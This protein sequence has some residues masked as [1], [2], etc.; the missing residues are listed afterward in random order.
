L[1]ESVIF[2]SKVKISGKLTLKA[3]RLVA[4]STERWQNCL[5]RELVFWSDWMLLRWEFC[6]CSLGQLP[7]KAIKFYFSEKGW[8]CFWELFSSDR[9]DRNALEGVLAPEIWF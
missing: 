9:E 3:N 7:S 8:N 6:F 2:L 4:F 5:F 1:S